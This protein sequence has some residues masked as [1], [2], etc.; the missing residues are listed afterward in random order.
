MLCFDRWKPR[1]KVK[2][3]GFLANKSD[4]NLELYDLVCATGLFFFLQQEGEYGGLQ[5]AAVLSP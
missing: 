5:E 1:S 3:N 4:A 2:F